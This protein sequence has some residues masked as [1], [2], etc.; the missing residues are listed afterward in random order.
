MIT[1][2]A[3]KLCEMRFETYTEA[4]KYAYE[5]RAASE[6]AMRTGDRGYYGNSEWYGTKDYDHCQKLATS[7]WPE[8]RKKVQA[9]RVMMDRIMD[10]AHSARQECYYDVIGTGGFDIGTA[11]T[12]VPECA[13]EW[14]D[15]QVMENR[16]VNSGKI[17]KFLVNCTVSAGVPSNV[18]ETRGAVIGAMIDC[19]EHEG[20]SVEVETTYYCS[21]WL[22]SGGTGT[23]D[24][25]IP[26]KAAGEYLQPDQMAFAMVSP[27]WLR[28]I[29][30][31]LCVQCGPIGKQASR[32][33]GYGSP[34][35][36]D[37]EQLTEER[38]DLYFPM[39][40]LYDTQWQSPESAL[41]WIKQQ[42]ELFGIKLDLPEKGSKP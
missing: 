15:T 19:L 4:V 6:A 34:K 22:D 12:G 8:G 37:P 14:Q 25:R 39:A 42:L 26:I 18:I 21:Q 38:V 10:S 31:S 24:I 17:I 20:Y 35:E 32:S 16:Q 13:I 7:G 5:H 9:M 28:R 33:G 1:N 2:F 40:H 36:V 3:P 23:F 27:S 41:P 29:G 11:L 30:F